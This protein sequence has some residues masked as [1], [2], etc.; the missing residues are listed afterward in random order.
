[1]IATPKVRHNRVPHEVRIRPLPRPPIAY[2]AKEAVESDVI[3]C[4]SLRPREDEV[5][6]G[7]EVRTAA[8]QPLLKIAI[9]VGRQ[10]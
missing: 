8:V 1:M 3:E 4:A 10:Q 2:A 9:K 7:G 5:V 6:G